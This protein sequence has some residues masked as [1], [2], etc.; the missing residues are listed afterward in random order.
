MWY[1]G[2]MSW[3]RYLQAPKMYLVISRT[4][5]QHALIKVVQRAKNDVFFILNLGNKKIG[6]TP[7]DHTCVIWPNTFWGLV[8]IYLKSV[9]PNI[10][11]RNVKLIMGGRKKNIFFRLQ[12]KDEQPPSFK[13]I[14]NRSIDIS[15]FFIFNHTFRNKSARNIRAHYLKVKINQQ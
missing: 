15:P 5:G 7:V 3:D 8:S 11:P 2:E 9:P 12:L 6:S 4:C 13:I 1:L 14:T 10:M